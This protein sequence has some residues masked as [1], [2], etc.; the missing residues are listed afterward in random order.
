MAKKT[1]TTLPD[2]ETIPLEDEEESRQFV[3]RVGGHRVRMAYDRSSDRIFLTNLE[4]PKT[5]QDDAVA[6]KLTEKVLVWAEENR[7][8]VV[9]YCS[10]VKG[11]MRRHTT[12]QRLLLKGVQL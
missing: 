6:A 2:L 11:F 12:W 9:P 5:I 1:P 4:V 8:K 10:Y 7:L 3:M